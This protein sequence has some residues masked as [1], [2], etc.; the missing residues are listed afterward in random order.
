MSIGDS[1]PAKRVKSELG[2]ARQASLGLLIVQPL[3]F[4]GRVL[5]NPR[6]HIPFDIEGFHLPLTA[7]IARCIR[8][9]VLPLWDPYSYC[10]APIHADLQAQLFYPPTWISI[11]LGNMSAGHRL[12]YWLEWMIPLHMILAGLFTFCLL[13]YLGLTIAPAFFGASV[14]QLGG[15]FASQAQHLGAICCAAW[16]PLVLLCIWRLSREV[17]IKWTAILAAGLALSILAGFMAG[18]LVVVIVAATIS[19]VLVFSIGARLKF[20]AAVLCG[21]ILGLALSAIQLVPTYQLTGYSVASER[22][23][24]LGTGGGLRIESLVSLVWPNYYHIYT[25]FDPSKFKQATNFTF[26]YVYCGIL[27]LPLI[28]AA[29]ILKR[30]TYCRLFFGL[31]A[32]SAVWMLG[33]QTP[34]YR[35]VFRRLPPLL[36]G[37]LYAEYALMA[38]CLFAALTAAAA[39]GRLGRRW[40]AGLPWAIAL[41]TA[42]DLIASGAGRPMNA[43]SGSYRS[44]GNEYQMSGYPGVLE[45]MRGLLS[46][47]SPPSRIDYLGTDGL[48]GIGGAGMLKLPTADGDNPFALKRVLALRRLF[49]GGNW[50]ERNLRVAD[51]DAPLLNALNVCFLAA[52]KEWQVPPAVDRLP[53]ALEAYDLR[54]YRNPGCLPRFFLVSRLHLAKTAAQAISYLARPDFAPADE[55][56]VEAA[57]LPLDGPLSPGTVEVAQYSANRVA[58]RVTAAGRAFLAS[59][60]ILYPGW[61]VTVDGKSAPFYMT[62]GAFRGVFL[63][64]GMHLVVMKFWPASLA[65]GAIVTALSFMVLLAGLLAERLSRKKPPKPNGTLFTRWRAGNSARSR[66]SAGSVRLKGGCGQDWPPSESTAAPASYM[67]APADLKTPNDSG[68][69]S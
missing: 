20:L 62:N 47:S 35:F 12:F 41:F 42:A 64:A 49:C 44:R 16:L 48:P 43:L 38:F 1:R 51:P 40:P 6:S 25:P 60:D 37:S 15:F 58:L 27:T 29:P 10:G 31:T 4:Y 14:Y 8:E 56:V 46:A 45:K 28:L 68:L 13:R 34:V 30:A 63:N 19:I 5:F 22:P 52:R 69:P 61:T 36:R 32:V 9:G 57:N 53:V 18:A 67:P 66:L 50:W 59:S 55:A 7:Y 23:Q 17:T 26:L 33:D 3:I 54:V 11:V 39:L 2:L 65:T 21:S 24:A